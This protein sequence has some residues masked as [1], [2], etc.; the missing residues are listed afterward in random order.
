MTIAGIADPGYGLTDKIFTDMR[1]RPAPDCA[2]TRR[3]DIYLNR[4]LIS[5]SYIIRRR[6]IGGAAA[7]RSVSPL[8]FAR[9]KTL[10]L[11]LR[12]DYYWPANP[13]SRRNTR[14]RAAEAQLSDGAL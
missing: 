9:R 2:V 1:I 14:Q 12:Q 5:S 10:L 3:G 8:A 7:A 6:Q 4:G 13:D 11:G